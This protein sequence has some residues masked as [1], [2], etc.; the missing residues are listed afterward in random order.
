MNS[1]INATTVSASTKADAAAAYP[2]VMRAVADAL[3][4][5]TPNSGGWTPNARVGRFVTWPRICWVPKKICSAW[6]LFCGAGNADDGGTLT[7]R[8]WT[9]PTKFK[10]RTTQ[11]CRL[12][13]CARTTVPTLPRLPSVWVV[14]PLFWRGFPWTPPW[15]REMLRCVW[16][17]C[18]M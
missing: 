14:S 10:L 8:S 7:F 5:L 11:A 6:P 9:Q 16:G 18:S 13:C 3:E 2:P 15:L 1:A 4:V 17:T 12:Q